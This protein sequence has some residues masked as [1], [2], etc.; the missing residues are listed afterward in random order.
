LRTDQYAHAPRDFKLR[1]SNDGTA[2]VDLDSRVN[3]TAISAAGAWGSWP[4]AGAVEAYRYLRF[5]VT[6]THVESA[7]A[8]SLNISEI[9]FY[10]VLPVS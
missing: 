5:E 3:D 1:G 4:V 10:G 8:V 6:K 7:G 2:W 9:E